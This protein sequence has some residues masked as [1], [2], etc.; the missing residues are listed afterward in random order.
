MSY[1]IS[2][3]NGRTLVVLADQSFDKVSTSITLIGKN[4]N[5]YGQEINNNFVHMLE[6]FA[7]LVE[8]DSPVQGQLWFDTAEGRIKVYSTSSFKPVGGPVVSINR[9]S[10]SVTGDLWINSAEKQLFWYDGKDYVSVGNT[11]TNASGWVVETIQDFSNNDYTVANLYSNETIIASATD[12]DITLNPS[13]PFLG[14]TTLR[15]GITLAPGFPIHGTATN[16]LAVA[17]F[18]P[19]DYI[20]KGIYQVTTGTV[21]FESTGGIH[22]GTSSDIQILSKNNV[23]YIY[24]S[25]AGQNFELRYNTSTNSMAPALAVD[26]V[27]NRMGIFTNTAIT[28]LDVN[29]DVTIRGELSVRGA[30]TFLESSTLQVTD[31]NIEIGKVTTPSEV[32][33][34]GGGITLKGSPDHTITYSAPSTRWDV[35]DTWNI[36]AGKT[37]Q[38]NG[39]NVVTGNSLGAVI[40]G[41]SLTTVGTLTNLVVDKKITVGTIAISNT[42]TSARLETTNG[43]AIIVNTEL[44][45]VGFTVKNLATPILNADAATKEYVDDNILQAGGGNGFRKTHTMSVDITP[46]WGQADNDIHSYIVS[47][48]SKMLPIN[49]YNGV[50]IDSTYAIPKG[51]RANVMCSYFTATAYDFSLNLGKSYVTVNKGTGTNNQSVLFD[52]GSTAT[53]TTATSTAVFLPRVNHLV[54]SFVVADW[55]DPLSAVGTWTFVAN[56][57]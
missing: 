50:S 29:G 20:K 13:V 4:V 43:S 11:T 22:V 46:V 17:G 30:T 57:L 10:G 34:D 44:D 24:N 6:N 14:T 1:T 18:V 9:P 15:A 55:T 48:L 26:V 49:G 31:K 27:N 51:A 32:T 5:A 16:T 25:L 47:Y 33:A 38:I 12:I 45:M 54:K 28:T 40:T 39:F 52:V 56:I 21:S 7:G 2:L 36:A 3:T 37:L 42:W 35:S 53:V 19:N 23:A 8:P 41:S